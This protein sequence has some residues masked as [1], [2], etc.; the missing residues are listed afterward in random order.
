MPG[1][2]SS[3]A[4]SDGQPI[5][6]AILSASASAARH[7]GA[8]RAADRRRR[9]GHLPGRGRIGTSS[10]S[11][12]LAK[13]RVAADWRAP[14][15]RNAYEVAWLRSPAWRCR[16]RAPA[17]LG[18]DDRDRPLRHG[19][20]AR[21]NPSGVEGRA[22]RR[23]RSDPDFAAQVGGSGSPRSTR[24]RPA[25]PRIATR[26]D[27][28]HIFRPIRLDAYLGATGLRHPGA[29]LAPA[30]RWRRRPPR[31][32]IALVHGDVSPKNILVGP[33]GPVFLDAECAWY[34]DPAF[35]LAF[36]L[37]HLL[38]K[39]D[40][41]ASRRRR[42]SWQAMTRS[43]RLPLAASIGRLPTGLEAA[44]RRASARLCSSPASTASR[45]S[46]T[47]PGTSDRTRSGVSP[48]PLDR[49][50]G[51]AAFGAARSVGGRV[52]GL[53]MP[54]QGRSPASR[55]AASGIRAAARRSRSRSCSRGA[56]AGGPSHRP[57]PRRGRARRSTGAMAGRLRWARRP[58]RGRGRQSARSPRRSPARAAAD[59][60][61]HRRRADRPRRH[62]G[63]DAA[64]RQCHR[65]DVDGGPARSR[66]RGRPP[67]LASPRGRRSRCACRCPRSRSSAAAPM[68]PGAS[69]SR[70]SWSSRPGPPPSP[71]RS[72]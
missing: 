16:A 65:R 3:A 53:E 66:G 70:T 58:R 57:G 30:K 52:E 14:V 34:G 31:R 5:L 9:L 21:R 68:P 60:A 22:A 6:D 19:V 17:I 48:A 25:T 46:S 39:A 40:R 28:L 51:G 63:Q 55:D 23:A 54:S 4:G 18:H 10:S 61:R 26:F 42:R 35:D 2:R 50:A 41:R 69:T 12:L 49:R 47:S 67:A 11:E 7:S 8:A 64:R 32:S 29:R 33:H 56:R 62:A 45:R 44:R 36:C 1:S 43:P 24:A 20:P 38:L 71:R 59:Q 15:E 27:T 37:N 72:T 13:L